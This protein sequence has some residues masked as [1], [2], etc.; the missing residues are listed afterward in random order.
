MRNYE[1]IEKEKYEKNI[2][3]KLNKIND[4][5]F[6]I[7]LIKDAITYE[8]KNILKEINKQNKIKNEILNEKK[9]NNIIIRDIIWIGNYYFKIKIIVLKILQESKI[10]DINLLITKFNNM[11]QKY[12]NLS[13]KFIFY[14]LEIK[15]LKTLLTKYNDSLSQI[16]NKNKTK[17]IKINLNNYD[18]KEKKFF[19]IPK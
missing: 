9:K 12:Q 6:Q 2:M 1:F 3:K 13:S 4:L 19:K 10:K 7:N 18:V 5:E 16:L 17:N 14:N 11:K 8:D 15:R